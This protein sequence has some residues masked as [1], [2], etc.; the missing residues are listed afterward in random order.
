MDQPI[1]GKVAKILSSR[2]IVLN[3]GIE[4]GVDLGMSFD[5]MAASESDIVD[6]DTNEVLGSIRRPRVRVKVTHIQSKISVASTF[7]SKRVNLGGSGLF[8]NPA[9][10]FGPI[11]RSLMPPSW[12]SEYE[13]LRKTEK[14]PETF[15]EKD[16]K[17][18]VGD[19]VVQVMASSEED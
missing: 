8:L 15:N 3:I 4:H 18:K 10:R 12:V 16:S 9:L 2:E 19:P 7:Q 13:T 6:P 1:Q 14:T 17:I 11:A 5:V